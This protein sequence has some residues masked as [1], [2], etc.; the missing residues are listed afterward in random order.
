[1]LYLYAYTIFMCALTTVC[2]CPFYPPKIKYPLPAC[3]YSRDYTEFRETILHFPFQSMPMAIIFFQS[4]KKKK[5]KWNGFVSHALLKGYVYLLPE[6]NRDLLKF[7]K[8]YIFKLS[9]RANKREYFCQM[10]K[11]VFNDDE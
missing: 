3:L 7:L 10:E 8:I 2:V 11:F 5:K 1:M 4:K 9:S 6:E